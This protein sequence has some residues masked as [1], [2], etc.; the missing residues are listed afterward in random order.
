MKKKLI[1]LCVVIVL[2]FT[3]YEVMLKTKTVK[4][5]RVKTGIGQLKLMLSWL[6]LKEVTP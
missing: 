3:F 6:V 4:V 2:I 1:W 5:I